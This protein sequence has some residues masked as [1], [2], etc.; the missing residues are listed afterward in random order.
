MDQE[1]AKVPG[2][3]RQTDKLAFRPRNWLSS[4]GRLPFT[5]Q[6]LQN[7]ASNAMMLELHCNGDSR[8]SCLSQELRRVISTTLAHSHSLL[9]FLSFLTIFLPFFLCSCF[10]MAPSYEENFTSTQQY[11]YIFSFEMIVSNMNVHHI[12]FVHSPQFYCRSYSGRYHLSKWL[13]TDFVVGPTQ[14]YVSPATCLLSFSVSSSC[15]SLFSSKSFVTQ[16]NLF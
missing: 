4:T 6:R 14:P 13:V 1:W 9:L 8:A 12:P 2:D 16:H 3:N 10:L 5:F 7:I 15:R 11:L